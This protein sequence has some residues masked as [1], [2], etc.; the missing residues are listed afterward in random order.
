M[1]TQYLAF[2]G[3]RCPCPAWEQGWQTPESSAGD[4]RGPAPPGTCC[5][6]RLAGRN[7]LSCC[8]SLTFLGTGPW[9]P[10]PPGRM[11][12]NDPLPC[13]PTLPASALHCRVSVLLTA[14]QEPGCRGPCLGVRAGRRGQ[15]PSPAAISSLTPQPRLPAGHREFR[16]SRESTRQSPARL[17]PKLQSPLRLGHLVRT[18]R[19]G[20]GSRGSQR[21]SAARAFPQPGL[22]LHGLW[23]L[24]AHTCPPC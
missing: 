21:C 1:S 9:V 20:P 13:Q 16:M 18:C 4:H 8:H 14:R 7:R 5:V 3:R 11:S 10:C 24:A 17:G 23:G 15:S 19:Q 2:C 12:W 6:S 22:P